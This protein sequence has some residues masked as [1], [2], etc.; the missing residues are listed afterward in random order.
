MNGNIYIY[1]GVMAAVT[2]LVR[3]L[4]AVIFRKKIKSQAVKSFLYY[5]PYAVLS[6][7]T[8]PA[9]FY[10]TGSAIS[11]AAGFTAAA[12]LSLKGKSLIIAAAG[13]CLS[14]FLINLLLSFI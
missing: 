7:M 1:I 8:I 9:V 11:A 4:P 5:M 12:V 14:V 10:S 13:A 2:Y 6:A 3:M